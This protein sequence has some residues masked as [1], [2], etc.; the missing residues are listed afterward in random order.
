M[1]TERTEPFLIYPDIDMFFYPCLNSVLTNVGT[2]IVSRPSCT[3]KKHNHLRLLHQVGDASMS[4]ES[5]SQARQAKSPEKKKLHGY[6][7]KMSEEARDMEEKLNK[8]KHPQFQWPWRRSEMPL[9][10]KNSKNAARILF[11]KIMSFVWQEKVDVTVGENVESGFFGITSFTVHANAREEFD[12]G[13]FS[14]IESK[15][16]KLTKSQLYALK[17]RWSIAGFVEKVDKTTGVLIYEYNEGLYQCLKDRMVRVRTKKEDFAGLIALKTIAE[18]LP[19]IPSTSAECGVSD[20]CKE[21]GSQPIQRGA[22]ATKLEIEE[23][24]QKVKEI[25]K[26]FVQAKSKERDAKKNLERACQT[27]ITTAGT[28]SLEAAI[29][30]S[31]ASDLEGQMK[32]AKIELKRLLETVPS[33]D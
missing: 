23:A 30:T 13:P 9:K 24:R 5:I 12:E 7:T 20:R 3:Y 32:A 2:S 4:T 10:V 22:A 26:E 6:V 25:E 8:I 28:L 14:S 33:A 11:M 19:K 27:A 1:I 21:S 15:R 18:K 31:L 16:G 29:H 17:T